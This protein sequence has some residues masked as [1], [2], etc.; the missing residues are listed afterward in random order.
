MI[1]RTMPSVWRRAGAIHLLGEH[2]VAARNQSRLPRRQTARA[3]PARRSTPLSSIR[4]TRK[5]LGAASGH[6]ATPIPDTERRP[7]RLEEGIRIRP[8]R[9]CA[10]SRMAAF[11]A[12]IASWAMAN[13]TRPRRTRD[14]NSASRPTCDIAWRAAAGGRVRDELDRADVLLHSAVSE[15]FCN[16]VMEAQ[17]MEVAGGMHERRR[18]A[19]ERR[20]W[21]VTGI[22]VSSARRRRD[23]R[24]ALAKLAQRS[25]LR[26][27]WVPP[28]RPRVRSHFPAHRP[29]RGVLRALRARPRAIIGVK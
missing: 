24:R 19:G 1:R 10:I 5:S 26:R 9:Q 7:P 6:D 15:G 29:D 18:V 12:S 2:L 14:I 22:V 28:G 17:A 16:A 13:S 21:R 27:T 25:G 3:D 23:R 8:C 4:D 11:T 20:G